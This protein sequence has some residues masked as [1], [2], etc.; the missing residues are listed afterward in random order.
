MNE[1]FNVY[2]DESCHLENDGQPVMLLGAV[3]CPFEEV[4]RLSNE[5]SDIKQRHK[6]AGELK[7]T[8]VSAAR[9]RFYLDLVDWFLAE[10]P[11]GTMAG[12]LL[13]PDI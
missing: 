11:A 4:K 3:W 9:E 7:W 5:L 12:H 1:I 6:A 8:K 13:S 10:K 2:C